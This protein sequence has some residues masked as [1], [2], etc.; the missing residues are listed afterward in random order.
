[1]QQLDLDAWRGLLPTPT[2]G[3]RF[4]GPFV[5]VCM[6]FSHDISKTDQTMQL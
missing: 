5:C 3:V 6:F 1:M 4:F 2:V